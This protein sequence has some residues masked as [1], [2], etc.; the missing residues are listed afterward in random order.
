M[1]S[2]NGVGNNGDDCEN[3]KTKWEFRQEMHP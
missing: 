2:N 1:N 3:Y